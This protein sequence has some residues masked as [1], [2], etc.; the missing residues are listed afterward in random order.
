MKA[1]K[2][3]G[4]I[5][6]DLAVAVIVV[7][8]TSAVI[9]NSN[10]LEEASSEVPYQQ[11][12]IIT[13]YYSPLPNQQ[14]YTTGSYEAEIRLN[15]SGVNGASGRPVFPGMIAAPKNYPFG[16]K[17][18][19]PGVGVVSVQDRG[20]AIVNA[21]QR[22]YAHDRLDIWMGYG[23]AGLQRALSWGKRTVSVTV[24]GVNDSIN[25][26]IKLPGYSPSEAIANQPERA[27][28]TI[29]SS[30]TPAQKKTLNKVTTNI[31]PANG[32]LY[33]GLQG[34]SVAKLQEKLDDLNFYRGEK[35]GIYDK[36]T[37]HAVFKF[38]QSQG[39][40]KN[41]TDQG[42]GVYGPQTQKAM[43][44]IFNDAPV[45]K[46]QIAESTKKYQERKIQVAQD[47][48]REMQFGEEGGHVRTLQQ[49]LKDQGHFTNGYYTDYFGRKTQQAVYNF[50]VAHG[51]V[52]SWA[53]TGAGRVGPSTLDMLK[54]LS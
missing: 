29:A 53:D 22:N 42:A 20:G 41:K 34:E 49:L 37:E 24:Y 46:T 47:L 17:M 39:V 52:D 31:A 26:A 5:T 4:I 50:Q 40:L 36:A 35:H 15:G 33:E 38:Q 43:A 2:F 11:D 14:K 32:T 28:V 16:T 44:Q 6:L 8:L 12:F 19:I 10:I 13:A 54:K 45:I 48:N 9:A 3:F 25:E 21:G 7:L 23:D 51:L 18:E 1:L 30:N 27:P